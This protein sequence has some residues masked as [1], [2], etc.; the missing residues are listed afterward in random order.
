MRTFAPIGLFVYNR[1]DHTRLTIEALKDNVFSE[2]TDLFIFSDGAKER[3]SERK[4]T[5]VRSY[6]RSVT[7]FKSITIVHRDKNFGLAGSIIDGV[8]FLV[9][10]FGRA[11]VVEDDLVT[12]KYFLHYMNDAL[13]IYQDE[14]DV[15]C[16][17]GYLYPVRQRLPETFFIRGADCWG[18]GTWKR[19]WEIFERDAGKLLTELKEK[20]LEHSFDWDGNYGN[21]KMLKEQIA[22]KVDSWAIRWHASA[23]IKNK[24][25]LYPGVS[26]VNNIGGDASGTHTKSLKGFQTTLAQSPVGVEKLPPIENK[27]SRSAFVEFFKSI[28]P[29]IVITIMKRI[30][31]LI[32]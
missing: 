27:E 26:L 21:V 25:T 14:P 15:V 8:S 28:K 24:L 3:V 19:G 10:K 20:D 22:G 6:I 16:I 29:S 9:Q 12:S 30:A 7:G 31:A 5:E 11:I 13:D 32:R 18:W 23:F 17:H 1:P 4:V 2:Q